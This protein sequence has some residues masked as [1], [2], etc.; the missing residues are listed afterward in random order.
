MDEPR[1]KRALWWQPLYAKALLPPF[2]DWLE[3]EFPAPWR[4]VA[5]I[6]TSRQGDV[7]EE[8]LVY[9]QREG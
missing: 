8:R 4:V 9:A 7:R 1:F 5:I 3:Q 6:D 2:M